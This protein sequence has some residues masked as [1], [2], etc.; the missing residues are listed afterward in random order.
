MDNAE[1]LQLSKDVSTPPTVVPA[2]EPS[3]PGFLFCFVFVR[4]CVWGGGVSGCPKAHV[5][6]MLFLKESL[7][8][9]L[10]V[11]PRAFVG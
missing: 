3:G 9:N 1:S 11:C 6:S 7:Q 8:M 10:W 4:V 5:L 2:D